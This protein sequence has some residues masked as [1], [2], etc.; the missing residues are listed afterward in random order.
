MQTLIH[1]IVTAALTAVILA[2]PVC[3]H[4]GQYRGPGEVQP[5]PGRQSTGSGTSSDGSSNSSNSASAA[6][7]SSSPSSQAS[8]GTSTASPASSSGGVL[9][10]SSRGVPLDDDLTR[11]EFWWE[12][13][14]DPFLRLRQTVYGADNVGLDDAWLNPRLALRARDVMPPTTADLDHVKERIADL[15]GQAPGR[16]TI[17]ASLIALAKIGRDGNN[18]KLRDRIVPFLAR[19][20]QEIRETAAL[21]L[22]IAGNCDD[23]TLD[24]LIALL[25]DDAAGRK[26]S[27]DSAVNERTRAFAAFGLGLLL[28]DADRVA[29]AHCMVSALTA[30]LDS[31]R[32]GRELQ[33]A[34]IEALSLLPKAWSGAGQKAL[35]Q[36]IVT[37]LERFYDLP[38]G[39]GLQLVQAHVPTAIGRLLESADVLAQRW[40]ERLVGELEQGLRSGG[41]RVDR[42]VNSHIAQSA[43]LALGSL[44]APWCVGA[45]ESERV[46]RLLL[47]LYDSHKDHQTRWFAVLA[48]GR[49]G[50][51]CSQ[52]AL[53]DLLDGGNRA[54][55]QP[56][57]GIALGVL[58]ARHRTEAEAAHRAF[59][60]D[61]RIGKQLLATLESA[62]NPSTKAALAIALG[63][64]GYKEAGDQLR[65]LLR[66]ESHQDD[67]AGYLSIALGL[68]RDPL[69]VGDIRSLLKDSSSRSQVVLHCAQSLGMLGDNAVVDD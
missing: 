59:E 44:T 42:K 47:R 60:A 45:T 51:E 66:E 14:K 2:G 3:A 11:W 50:G 54:L 49:I 39:P 64:M 18:W 9:S 12:F 58:Q 17:S 8:S 69:A 36:G 65:S 37:A 21:A 35:R 1:P 34:S 38:L 19:N 31:D 33:V 23:A 13:G 4:G 52:Q 62:R 5:S 57:I 68:M 63:L 43:V 26:L 16:D 56:W 24:V 67:L 48:L 6:T 46:G 7:N 29:S 61:R 53:L 15:L 41:R 32:S 30:V 20:D 22:G 55:E 10:P 27:G 28:R 25:Q 40:R